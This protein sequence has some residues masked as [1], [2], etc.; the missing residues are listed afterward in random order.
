MGIAAPEPLTH[1]IHWTLVPVHALPRTNW[2]DADD[3]HRAVMSLF[4][5]HLP[6]EPGHKRAEHHILFRRD[7]PAGPRTSPV[8]LIQSTTAPT[9]LP[10]GAITRTISPTVWTPERDETIQFRLAINPLARGGKNTNHRERV[11]TP[12]EVPAWLATRL[13]DSLTDLTILDHRRDTYKRRGH[14]L[15]IDTIDGAARV[16]NPDALHHHRL[17]GIGRAKTYGAGLLTILRA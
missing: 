10:T 11:L 14:T 1:T 13:G 7:L 4:D 15:T 16:T 9:S 5:P 17:H 6:G 3:T 8:V 12:D 2:A